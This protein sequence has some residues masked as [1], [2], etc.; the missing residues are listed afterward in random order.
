[1]STCS[2]STWDSRGAF[3]IACEII[4]QGIKM[5]LGQDAGTPELRGRVRAC[6]RTTSF[7]KLTTRPIL[8][9]KFQ[10]LDIS[11]SGVSVGIS[12]VVQKS[13]QVLA[14]D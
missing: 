11:R 6:A 2:I 5:C 4:V 13:T 3:P 9:F 8:F 7:F 12:S 10:K 1:M 14:W